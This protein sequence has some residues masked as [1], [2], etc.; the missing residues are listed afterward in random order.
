M[1]RLRAQIAGICTLVAVVSLAAAQSGDAGMGVRSSDI[2]EGLVQSFIGGGLPV[3]PNAKSFREAGP[4]ARVAFVKAFLATA[5]EFSQSAAF[6]ADYA[7]RRESARPQPPQNKGSAAEQVSAQQTA[8]RKQLEETRA[9][10][11]KMPPDMQKQMQPVLKMMEESLNKSASDPRYQSMMK[12][13][14]EQQG[15]NDQ[16]RYQK[17]LAGWQV[18]YPENPNQL[19]I[20]RLKGFLEMTKDVDFNARLTPAGSKMHF[21]D[22]RYESKSSNWKL[23]YRA[24]REPLEAARAFVADWLRQLGAN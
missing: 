13:G 7:K 10:I 8:Q 5:R 14:Y 23:C 2:R 16:E 4:A 9:Q 18:D 19:I 17:D 15:K 11:A 3:Y 6:R 24:G 21:S 1:G 22:P 20:K 12:Q